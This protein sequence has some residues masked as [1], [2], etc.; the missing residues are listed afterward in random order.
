LGMSPKAWAAARR[1]VWTAVVVVDGT[2]MLPGRCAN[3]RSVGPATKQDASGRKHEDGE[4][5]IL[6]NLNQNPPQAH[7]QPSRSSSS[8]ARALHV[9]TSHAARPTGHRAGTAPLTSGISVVT[10][11]S[12]YL[13]SLRERSRRNAQQPA[14]VLAPPSAAWGRPR[15]WELRTRPATAAYNLKSINCPVY[16]SL[17]SFDNEFY[18]IPGRASRIPWPTDHQGNTCAQ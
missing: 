17:V 5:H 10:N 4:R 9:G 6:L 16:T 7:Q 18:R 14:G 13:I 12:C 3:V 8:L 15:T 11:S 2:S 1:E